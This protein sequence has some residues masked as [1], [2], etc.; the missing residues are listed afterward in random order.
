[1]P[2]RDIIREVASEPPISARFKGD[3]VQGL[4]RLFRRNQAETRKFMERQMVDTILNR[5]NSGGV[6]GQIYTENYALRKMDEVGWSPADGVDLEY[7]GTLKRNLTAQSSFN[8]QTN[9]I[10]VG[11]T[12]KS[13]SRPTSITNTRLAKILN[14]EIPTPASKVGSKGPPL[15]LHDAEEETLVRQAAQKILDT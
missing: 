1:M 6:A 8:S 15:A 3:P 14:G 4:R 7:S 13:E 2:S 11:L 5:L 12:F 9:R 10:S